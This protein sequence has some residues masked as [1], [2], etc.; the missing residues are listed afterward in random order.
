MVN[1]LFTILVI[2]E[3]VIVS[4]LESQ[5]RIANEIPRRVLATADGSQYFS[6]NYVM[7]CDVDAMRFSK[8]YE[9]HCEN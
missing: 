4:G 1:L 5:N 9:K 7:E 6:N 2:V 8:G 3:A